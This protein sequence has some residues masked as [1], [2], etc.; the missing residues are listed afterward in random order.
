MLKLLRLT[1]ALPVIFIPLA[2]DSHVPALAQEYPDCFLM[3]DTGEYIDLGYICGEPEP[4]A[5][6]S[7]QGQT[8]G[9]G[10]VQ[11]TLRWTT[12]D[13]LDLAVT[14]PSGQTVTYFNRNVPSGG[15]LD[16]DANAACAGTTPNPVENIFWPTGG[17]PQGQYRIDVNLFSRCG[18]S[19]PVSFSLTVLIQGT[20]QTLT[21]TVSEERPI[22][23][24][25]FSLPLQA[26][27]Q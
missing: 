12:T 16:V 1:I 19:G 18:G 26:A 8:L 20:T 21:G 15:E 11:T 6:S 14:D 22:A 13:D 4:F 17:A 3:S 9:T 24:F 5:T 10:D 25:P 2:I 23:S 7:S 27:Q